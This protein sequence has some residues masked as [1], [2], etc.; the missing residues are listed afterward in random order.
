MCCLTN[1]QNFE[2]IV[3]CGTGLIVVLKPSDCRAFCMTCISFG[4]GSALDPTIW[5]VLPPVYL[6]LGEPAAFM[7]FVATVRSPAGFF[8]KSNPNPFTQPAA[9]NAGSV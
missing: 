7:Y 3:C 2:Y 6:P 1:P 8:R 9:L 5:T 4:P